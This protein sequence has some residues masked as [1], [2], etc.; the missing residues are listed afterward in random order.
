METTALPRRR[1]RSASWSESPRGSQRR[2]LSRRIS[3]RRDWFAGEVMVTTRNGR[4]SVVRPTSSARTRGEAAARRRK[5]SVIC[6]QSA[7]WPSSPGRKPSTL[8]GGGTGSVRSGS[9]PRAR[10]TRP[11]AARSRRARPLFIDPPPSL[12]LFAGGE[13]AALPDAGRGA[14]GGEADLARGVTAVGPEA[15]LS[16]LHGDG[17]EGECLEAVGDGLRTPELVLRRLRPGMEPPVV[18]EASLQPVVGGIEE[19]RILL[20]QV[21]KAGLRL[22]EAFEGPVERAV[23]R[24]E[25]F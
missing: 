2:R 14:V 12:E 9:A 16:G 21:G 10:A 15:G 11:A 13:A 8:S 4:P 23:A 17:G 6:D 24:R 1:I 20:R 19:G 5:Y 3:S 7:S 18:A 22:R 25:L